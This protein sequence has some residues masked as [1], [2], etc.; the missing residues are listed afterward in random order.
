MIKLN[1]RVAALKPSATMAAEARATELKQAGVNVISLAAG[2]PDF[3]TPERIKEAARKAMAA[4]QTKYTAVAGTLELREALA[5]KIKRENGLEY[6]PVEVMASAGGKQAS[7]NVIATL[8]DEGDEVIIP[9]PAWVSFAEM[10]RLSGADAK[11]VPTRERDGFRLSPD[12]LK[13]ALSPNTRG[14]I[15]NSPCNPTGTVY[16]SE[17]LA[18]LGGVLHQAG[19]WVLADGVYE[20]IVYDSP[21]PHIFQIE[22]QLKPKGILLNSL[23]KTYAMT[24]WRIGY[25][26]GPR[27]IISAAVR[28]QGQTSGNP[29]SITQTAAIEAIN[30]PQDEA[31][32]MVAEFRARREFVVERIRS[33]PGFK[34]PHVPEGAF[35][36]FPNVSALFG[37]KWK[38]G[39]LRDGDG[40]ADLLLEEAQVA[41]VG[42]NDFG[43]IEHIRISYANS[44]ANLEE[45]FHRIERLVHRLKF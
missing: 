37:G 40:V 12:E 45:A 15:L 26:A 25:A 32:S 6:S 24:G 19:L 23:S 29:N 41:V 42:G 7:Y 33:L 2:E 22:P 35:Y 34:L 5:Q 18:E 14:I 30:G 9:T 4:G 17:H 20:Q 44:R 10:V 21:V 16:R 38:G 1:R 8:F 28:L 36:A 13:R 43:S 27:E 11:L 39:T 3:D 31:A